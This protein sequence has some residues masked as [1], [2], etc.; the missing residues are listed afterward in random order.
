[1]ILSLERDEPVSADAKHHKT[2]YF[3]ET[4]GDKQRTKIAVVK[5]NASQKP[6]R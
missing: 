1:M 6:T 5:Q 2:K 3:Q 4:T